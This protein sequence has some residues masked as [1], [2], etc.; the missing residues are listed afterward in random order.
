M[1]TLL[2]LRRDLRI[3]DLPALGRAHD[4]AGGNAIVPLV[5]LDP[6]LLA[7]SPVRTRAYL[8]AVTAAQEAYDGALVVRTGRPETVV[9]QVAAEAD[10]A[11]VHVSAETT[12]Y[13]RRRDERVRDALGD[14]PLVAT[15]SPYAVT[16][17]RIRNGSGDPYKVF[18]PYSRAWRDH[19][20]PRPAIVPAGLRLAR[21]IESEDLPAL[22]ESAVAA[23][24][25]GPAAAL[26]R[27]HAFLE[28]DVTDYADR[29]DRPDLD[30]TSRLSAHLKYGTIHPRTLL[31]ALG[32]RRG[33]GA[34]TFVDELAWREF[35]ADVL[36]HHPDSAWNDLRRQL[37]G[38]GYDD[39]DSDGDAAA[40][41]DAWRA[42]RTGY[43]FVDAGMRQLLAEGWMHNRLRMVT[44]SFL[45]KHLHI[46]WP[47]GARH[48]LAHLIDGDLAS[49]NHGWQW[50]AGTGTDAAPY[51]RIFNPITQG[52]KFDPDGRYIRRY[53][54]ELGHLEGAAIHEPWAAPAGL[55]GGYPEPIVEHRAARAEALARYGHARGR[56]FP[57]PAG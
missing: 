19:G 48:F 51:F 22:P 17:G 44:A 33:A 41:L 37:A 39:P 34:H 55:A 2:W 36:W 12:P 1:R 31:A 28:E 43:P 3:E 4:Q 8:A 40:A 23:P 27:W 7:G 46:W 29:R 35:Y 18:T 21:T 47:H 38:M 16:P 6:G 49:N 56:S 57:D 25:L 15:G 13:G 10:A 9:P 42:G 14:I 32:R 11:G 54:P 45:V 52:R 24:A 5:V 30:G 20:W 50:V 26:E 53:V